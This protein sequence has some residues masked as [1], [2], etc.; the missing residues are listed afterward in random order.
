MLSNI[1]TPPSPSSINRQEHLFYRTPTSGCFRRLKSSHWRCSIKEAV[2]KSFAI[3]TEKH[4][5]WSFFLTKLQVVRPATFL[6]K[7]PTQVFSCKYYE[8]F[9]NTYDCRNAILRHI[10]AFF[11]SIFNSCTTIIFIWLFSN[12]LKLR[13]RV[14]S[15]CYLN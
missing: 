14:E 11:S 13:M 9:K 10:N 4:L 5:C 12:Q 7:T 3:L 2:F 8:I 15:I 1:R 6:K